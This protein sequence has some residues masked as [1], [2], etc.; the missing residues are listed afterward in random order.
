MLPEDTCGV[1]IA[2]AGGGGG[3]GV[4]I[5]AAMRHSDA[6]LPYAF[7]A[8]RRH[9]DRAMLLLPAFM[10][11]A[12]AQQTRRKMFTRCTL[13]R[14]VDR[15]TVIDAAGDAIFTHDNMLL[16]KPISPLLC[17]PSAILTMRRYAA[18]MPVC[19][20]IFRHS[21]DTLMLSRHYFPLSILSLFRQMPCFRLRNSQMFPTILAISAAAIAFSCHCH[22]DSCQLAARKRFHSC[23]FIFSFRLFCLLRC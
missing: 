5:D 8:M 6:P 14:G 22:S 1:A 2:G 11:A 20:L 13:S 17:P 10:F 7:D 12:A 15:D 21:A 23:R 9:A 19:P 18:M 4:A 16:I 3:A